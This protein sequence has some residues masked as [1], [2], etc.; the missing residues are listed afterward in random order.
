MYKR[1]GIFDIKKQQ[2]ND[3]VQQSCWRG[4]RITSES[5]L[6]IHDNI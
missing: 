4:S 3:K 1:V 6:S 5:T 2:K